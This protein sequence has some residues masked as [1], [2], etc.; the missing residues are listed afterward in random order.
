MLPEPIVTVLGNDS[1]YRVK[2]L[3]GNTFQ[4]DAIA[5]FQGWQYAA[6]YSP[7]ESRSDNALFV[8][9]AR[10]RL[11]SQEWERLV[12]EDYEQTAD[13][14]HNTVQLGICPGDGTIHLSYDHHCD[15]LRYRVS[16]PNL[17]L[18]P[19][20]FAWRTEQFSSSIDHLPGI[21]SDHPLLQEVTYPRFGCLD[22]DMFLSFRTGRAGLGSDHLF[23]YSGESS[24]YKCLGTNLTGIMNNPY[25][26]GIDYRD[27]KLHI[28]F[29][30]RGW[31]H[32][33]GWDDPLDTK[34]KQHS[35]PNGIGNNYDICYV[36]SEDQGVTWKNGAGD[37]IAV[38]TDP[39]SNS[40]RPDSPGITAFSIPK[41]TGLSNQEAQVVDHAGG[42]HILNRDRTSGLQM[43][44]HYYRNPA[45]TWTSRG[46][47]NVDGRLAGVRGQV[48]VTK[49]GDL[50]FVLP[51][52]DAPGTL[53]ILK[54]TKERDY[55]DY[56]LVWEKPGFPWEPLIDRYRLDED[57]V[58]SIFVVRKDGP[59]GP[60]KVVVLDFAV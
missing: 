29:T 36:Y 21:P 3:N 48:A 58:L 52:N 22:K 28:T 53:K 51:G 27:G 42:V 30:Y 25:V 44:K 8:H 49:S 35:G 57:N 45:G 46:L 12:F 39:F 23:V 17:A 47:P 54:A 37:V 40:V 2:Y 7:L 5:T 50:Y 20:D 59:T 55:R 34:H 24:T 11:P 16:V 32:Y 56:E 60:R 26:N 10:R 31:I 14:P 41:H 9:V 4:Q 15:H 19:E 13:D 6:Y 1:S 38:L 43:W 18:S 33:E